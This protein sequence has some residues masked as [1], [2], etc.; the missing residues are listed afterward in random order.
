MRLIDRLVREMPEAKS[1]KVI[2]AD[3]VLEGYEQTVAAGTLLQYEPEKYFNV[4]PPFDDFLI[5]ARAKRGHREIY[6]GYTFHARRL[7]DP[8][9]IPL[10][11]F[12]YIDRTEWQLATS[13]IHWER[14]SGILHTFPGLAIF[15]IDSYGKLLTPSDAIPYSGEEMLWRGLPRGG[16]DFDAFCNGLGVCFNTLSIL[17]CKNIMLEEVS[18]PERL[19]RRAEKKRGEP[20]SKYYVLKIMPRTIRNSI[21]SIGEARGLNAYHIVRGHF[22]TFTDAAPLFGKYTGTYWWESQARGKKDRGTI[23]KRYAVSPGDEP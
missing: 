22:K 6:I 19:S 3:E 10:R 4:A 18:P 23:E 20:L 8:G 9:Y 11:N 17:H 1:L 14:S 13:C 12:P 16:L 7:S 5:E 21:E 15:S 2:V